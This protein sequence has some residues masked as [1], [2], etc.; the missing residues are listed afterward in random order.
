MKITDIRLLRPVFLPSREMGDAINV[1]PGVMAYGF[2]EVLTDEGVTG[3]CPGGGLPAF[4]ESLKPYVVGEDPLNSERI[5][6]NW[7]GSSS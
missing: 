1:L 7:K 2:L 4:V 6:E 3:I 5:W